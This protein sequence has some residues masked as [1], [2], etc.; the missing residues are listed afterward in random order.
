MRTGRLVALLI[1]I[2]LGGLVFWLFVQP[3][4]K[5]ADGRGGEAAH[6][7]GRGPT[8]ATPS[9]RLYLLDTKTGML[10]AR[11]VE[12]PKGADA[13]RF[14]LEQLAGSRFRG[15]EA[16]SLV[17][18]GITPVALERRGKRVIVDYPPEFV[19][20]FPAGSETGYLTVQ[21]L[22]ATL[23]SIEGITEVEFRIQGK[24]ARAL[25]EVDVTPPVSLDRSVISPQ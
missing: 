18:R 19:E 8:P 9:V 15:A 20:K 25:G 21:S 2:G 14:A 3:V 1:G 4:F 10:L 12:V 24:T 7:E 16:L 6:P 17:P 22:V 11:P 5:A 23:T 13:A